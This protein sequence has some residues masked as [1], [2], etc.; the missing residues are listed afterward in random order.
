MNNKKWYQKKRVYIPVSVA[1]GFLGGAW[2]GSF[3]GVK[4]DDEFNPDYY[5]KKEAPIFIKK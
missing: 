5:K 1:M 3:L 4:L 2:I